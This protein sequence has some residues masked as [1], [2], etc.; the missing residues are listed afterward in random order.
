MV[1]LRNVK[2]FT[3]PLV[4]SYEK[5]ILCI[6]FAQWART[7]SFTYSLSAADLGYELSHVLS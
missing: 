7:G 4:Y 5:I 1:L 6:C 2:L 3:V